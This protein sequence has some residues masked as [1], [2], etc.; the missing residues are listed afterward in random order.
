MEAMNVDLFSYEYNYK[1]G[2]L[3]LSIAGNEIELEG[4]VKKSGKNC[5]YAVS[6]LRVDGSN[7][8]MDGQITIQKGAN[9]A[10]ISEKDVFDIGNASESDWEELSENME[11]LLD[12]LWY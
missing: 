3:E 6:N 2:D 7:V 10:K 9:Y 1:T 5:V 4:I 12:G 11:D 8:D